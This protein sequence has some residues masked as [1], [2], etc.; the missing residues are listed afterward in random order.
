MTLKEQRPRCQYCDKPLRRYRG[1]ERNPQRSTWGD[2]GDGFF[3]G[4]RCGYHW[5]CQ[6]LTRN[7]FL[8]KEEAQRL[9]DMDRIVGE[10]DDVAILLSKEVTKR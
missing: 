4:L 10:R 2:Y 6:S 8:R 5:A 1:R 7:P 3:C 9:A